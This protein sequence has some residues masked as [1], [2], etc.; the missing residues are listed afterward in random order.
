[1]SMGITHIKQRAAKSNTTRIVAGAVQ[2][3]FE[4]GW[5]FRPQGESLIQLYKDRP[6]LWIQCFNWLFHRDGTN[7]RLQ[8]DLLVIEHKAN[9]FFNVL[10][11][12]CQRFE[13][14]D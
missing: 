14:K 11:R 10:H 4:C 9:L 1:M 2:R 6:P 3:F 13:G 5:K 12:V 8:V 7:E